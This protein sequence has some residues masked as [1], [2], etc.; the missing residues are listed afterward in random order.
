MIV[1]PPLKLLSLGAD[2]RG[3]EAVYH[4]L[5]ESWEK[6]CAVAIFLAD[7]FVG[8]G[9]SPSAMLGAGAALVVV[10]V[11]S[12]FLIFFVFE[13]ALWSFVL[14]FL[15]LFTPFAVRLECLAG[16]EPTA[17]RLCSI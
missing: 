8:L 4:W 17:G 14:D 9:A 10:L 1:C 5:A 3:L 13:A 15:A 16:F 11:F 12:T 2:L 6:G 7:L